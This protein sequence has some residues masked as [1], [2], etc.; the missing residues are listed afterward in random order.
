M[1]TAKPDEPVREYARLLLELHTFDPMGD[2]DSPEQDAVCDQMEGPWSRMSGRERKR[3]KGLSQDL[4][5]LAHGRH[6]IPMTPE[7]KH[8]WAQSER[9]L[10]RSGEP[11]A[12][13]EHLR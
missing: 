9:A 5:A 4:Y 13:L 2:R 7:E 11:D 6:G 8:F 10:L 1:P 12:H 3:M